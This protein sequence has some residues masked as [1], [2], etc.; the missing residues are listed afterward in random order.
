MLSVE[1]PGRNR[2]RVRAVLGEAF[3]IYRLLFARSVAT[4]AVVYA[5]QAGLQL[6]HHGASP[7]AAQALAIPLFLIGL[8]GPV[9]VQGA[10][11]EIV[12]NVHEGRRPKPMG[13]LF[14]DSRRRF[15]RLLG[16]SFVYIL[17]IVLGLVLLIVPGLIVAARWCLLVPLIMLE[18]KS[19]GDARRVSSE[20]VRGKTSSVLGCLVIT[21]VLTSW[22]GVFIA[23]S[24]LGFGTRVFLAFLW[25]ALTAPFAA[26]VLT[27]VYYRLRDPGRPVVDPHVRTWDSVW[28]GR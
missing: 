19:V 10:L 25:S 23:F 26:H 28:E 21:W 5:I 17:G 4:A 14:R 8:G 2:P 6:L 22:F 15:W 12:R 7:A 9:L 16:A 24:H 20:L 1:Y 27:V 13:T 3:S 11:V 18:G